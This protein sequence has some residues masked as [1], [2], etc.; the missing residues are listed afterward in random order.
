MCDNISH[1]SPAC[2]LWF[3]RSR[4]PKDVIGK[5]LEVTRGGNLGVDDGGGRLAV[6]AA[7]RCDDADRWSVRYCQLAPDGRTWVSDLIDGAG[8]PECVHLPTLDGFADGHVMKF[9]IWTLP[10]KEGW[11]S[12]PQTVLALRRALEGT[13]ATILH[14]GEKWCEVL[15]PGVNKGSGV[16]RLLRGLGGNGVAASEV[17][18][19]GDAE[20]DVEM[21]RLAGIGAAMGNAQP[22]AREAADVIVPSNAEDGVADAIH[23]FVFGEVSE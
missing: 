2:L 4:L 8:E 15:P 21:L 1:S 18:A 12:M 16:E 17:L 7:T 9:V 10:G 14:H 22:A 13:G 3:A 23:R 6:L 19:L 20:N 5:V 11:A